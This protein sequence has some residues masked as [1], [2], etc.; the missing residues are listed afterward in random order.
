MDKKKILWCFGIL[1]GLFLILTVVGTVL[2][3]AGEGKVAPGIFLLEKDVSGLTS[4]ELKR[5]IRGQVPEVKL[6]LICCFPEELREKAQ[7]SGRTLEGV[8]VEVTDNRISL[9][10]ERTMIEPVEVKIMEAVMG[11]SREVTCWEWLYEAVFGVPFMVRRVIPEYS[12]KEGYFTELLDFCRGALT[13][14]AKSAEIQWDGEGIQIKEDCYGYSVNA[15][16]TLQEAGRV[17]RNLSETAEMGGL[18]GAVIKI[19][20]YGEVTVPKLTEKQAKLCNTEIGEYVTSYDGAGA[21]R[22]R[23]IKNGAGKLH[24]TVVLPG[25][26]FSVSKVLLPF[27]EENGYAVAGSYVNGKLSESIGG[28]VCQLSTT[29]YNA[30][31]YTKLSITRRQAHSL[32]VGYIPLGRDAA[33]AENLKDLCFRNTSDVPVLILCEADDAKVT[34]TLY[35]KESLKCNDVILESVVTEETKEK[36]TVNVFRTAAGTDGAVVREY[37]STDRY[38]KVQ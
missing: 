23:N 32:P 3:A 17:F 20:G 10:T 5:I 37:V 7:M 16:K 1:S 21:G 27:T 18:D 4:E 33:I 22:K 26:E 35:G 6:E 24:G 11:R 31:L 9:K 2:K 28:G 8:L 25:E 29:L 36:V 19:Y 12:W 30:L 38:K 34:V 14:E 15:E 13:Q